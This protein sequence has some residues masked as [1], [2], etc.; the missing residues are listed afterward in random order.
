[1]TPNCSTVCLPSLHLWAQLKPL[2]LYIIAL[3]N[4]LLWRW[5]MRIRSRNHIWQCVAWLT[6]L[7]L[8]NMVL[9]GSQWFIITHSE[10]SLPC[11][12]LDLYCQN[13][14]WGNQ[15][16]GKVG[17][18]NCWFE[19]MKPSCHWEQ[20]GSYY[21][22]QMQTFCFIGWYCTDAHSTCHDWHSLDNLLFAQGDLQK[23]FETHTHL[24][25]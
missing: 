15:D 6:V 14:Q 10:I 13:W 7:V 17:M 23:A 2:P 12:I 20:L 8:F 3:I 25:L 1:M 21:M 9:L 24:V 4:N 22:F 19:V 16:L 18:T 5:Y 11:S